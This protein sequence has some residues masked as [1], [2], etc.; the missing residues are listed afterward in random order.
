MK[1]QNY[2]RKLYLQKIDMIYLVEILLR[3]SAE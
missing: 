1:E 2:F 3:L